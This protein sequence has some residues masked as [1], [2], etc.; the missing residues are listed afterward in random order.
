MANFSDLS[1]IFINKVSLS[2]YILINT[3]LYVK[4]IIVDKSFD[5]YQ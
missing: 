3:V 4:Y 5:Y 2:V 1:F